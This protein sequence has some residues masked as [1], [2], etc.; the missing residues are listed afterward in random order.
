MLL[1]PLILVSLL[2]RSSA[3]NEVDILVRKY[4]FL[5]DELAE[6]VEPKLGHNSVTQHLSSSTEDLKLLFDIEKRLVHHLMTNNVSDVG[7][8]VSQFKHLSDLQSIDSEAYVSHPVNAFSLMKRTSKFWEKIRSRLGDDDIFRGGIGMG[9]VTLP[10]E[11]DFLNGAALGI[12]NVQYF[13][14]LTIDKVVNGTVTNLAS[15]QQFKANHRLNYHDALV[16]AQAA[17]TEH[18]YN[19]YVEWSK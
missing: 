15:G 7:D 4:P 8:Y 14:N 10:S 3:E 1:L 6:T 13:H 5:F 16:V 17:K 19:C 12:I 11:K 9:Q 18:R 2:H